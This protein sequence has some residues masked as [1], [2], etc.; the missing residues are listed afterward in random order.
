MFGRKAKGQSQQST[1]RRQVQHGGGSSQAFSY[2]TNRVSERSVEKPKPDRREQ[3]E[4][5]KK[6][7]FSYRSFF[8]GLPFW[9]L[10]LVVMVCAGKMLMLSSDPKII[11][12][13]RTPT[14]SIY[15]KP[16]A[17]YEAATRRLL[18]SSVTNRSKLTVDPN[19]V[20]Q[21]LERQFPEL[22]DVS[23]SIP[24]INSRPVVYIQPADPSLV[25]QTTHGNYALNKSGLVLTG[26]KALPSGVSLVVDQ[27]GLVPQPGK[28]ALSSGTVTFVKTVAYQ[29]N[30][31]HLTISTFVLPASSS[32]EVDARLEGQPYV[33]RFNLQVDALTQSGAAIATIRQL[34]STVPAA[35]LDVRVPG[36]VYYK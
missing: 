15:L 19:G 32:Y 4:T 9:L 22:E 11:V 24:L 7:S 28:Q 17:T 30:A 5:A 34:G 13:G 6:S 18:A 29:F 26:L 10:L 1:S 33:V 2:Y 31:A 35:Y 36:R 12:V 16:V 8:A 27:S 21:A 25:L 20:A 23:M 3:P 14:T